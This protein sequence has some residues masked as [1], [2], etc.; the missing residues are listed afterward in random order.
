M[1][2]LKF[3][4]GV[5]QLLEW[6]GNTGVKLYSAKLSAEGAHENKVAELALREI[7]LDE[8]EA[9]LNAQAKSEIRGRWYAPENMM[10]YFVALPYYFKAIT[11][12]NVLGSIWEM[13]WTTPGL[14]GDTA[15]AM[16][17]IMA[18]WF[19]QRAITSV[20]SVIAGAFGKKA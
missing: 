10:F 8:T 15:T 14:K 18:F 13:G 12:D 1:W 9:R 7:Q 3:I 11:L 20:A 16:A 5:S 2:L 4:P 17:M 6:I 19:G